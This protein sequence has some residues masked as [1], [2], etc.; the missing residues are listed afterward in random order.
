MRRRTI[1]LFEADDLG[2]RKI[3]LEPQDVRHLRAAPGVDRLIV[4]ADAADVLAV[5]GEQAEPEILGLVGVLIFVHENI[6]EAVLVELQHVPARLQD[7]QHVQ[8]QVAEIA[9]VKRLQPLLILRVHGRALAVGISFALRRIDLTWLPAAI[10]PAVDQPGELAR[11]PAFL[12]EIGGG[13]QLLQQPQLVVGVEDGEVGLQPDQLRVPPQHLGA[14][15]VEGA[16]PRHPLDRI[17]DD[18]PDPLAHLAR[19]LVGERHR[20]DFGRPG[21]AGGDEVGQPRR[22]RRRLARS[23]AGEHQHRPLGRQHRLALWI[24][25]AAEITGLRRS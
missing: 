4:V 1:I 25:E 6:F 12:F 22:Q 18:A 9:G 8:Q 14:D 23:R 5:L 17:A 2:A 20:Q 21:A 10:L 11:W 13:D 3:L 15:R 24:V 7:G 16:E 19:G